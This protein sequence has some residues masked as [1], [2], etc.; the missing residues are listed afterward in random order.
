MDDTTLKHAEI[1]QIIQKPRL[2]IWTVDKQVSQEKKADGSFRVTYRIDPSIYCIEQQITL[3]FKK[4]E[5]LTVEL[6]QNS[7]NNKFVNDCLRLIFKE[8]MVLFREVVDRYFSEVHPEEGK[9]LTS[10]QSYISRYKFELERYYGFLSDFIDKEDFDK[11]NE[12]YYLDFE[13]HTAESAKR[14]LSVDVQEVKVNIDVNLYPR[15]F[16]SNQAFIRFKKLLAEFG[17]SKHDLVN[18][19]F[20]YHRMLKDNLIFEDFQKLQ[21]AYFLINFDI[22]IDRIKRFEEIGNL[23]F[24]EDIYN[25]TKL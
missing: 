20:V 11:Y 5:F 10:R 8:L 25:K 9:M 7:K 2:V 12:I 19:S 1:I 6:M 4:L 18:Y 3:P 14:V 24:R 16:T 15:I 13:Y 23:K 22:N 21:F 17:K